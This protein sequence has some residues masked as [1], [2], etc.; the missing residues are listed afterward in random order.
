MNELQEDTELTTDGLLDWL[1]WIW[2]GDGERFYPPDETARE[3]M[4]EIYGEMEEWPHEKYGIEKGQHSRAYN[5]AVGRYHDLE[6]RGF[7]P[8]GRAEREIRRARANGL[9]LPELDWTWY[10]EN[11][12]LGDT[13]TE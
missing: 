9:D 1:C 3:C 8:R 11:P 4:E 10:D 12:R 2:A 13:D 6:Q 5:T 7:D